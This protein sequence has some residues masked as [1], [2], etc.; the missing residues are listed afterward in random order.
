MRLEI[1]M[2]MATCLVN[3][4][5]VRC[6]LAPCFIRNS[7]SVRSA[8]SLTAALWLF[9]L[10]YNLVL[11]LDGAIICDIFICSLRFAIFGIKGHSS[12]CSSSCCLLSDR[13]IIHRFMVSRSIKIVSDVRFSVISR[14][15]TTC[16]IYLYIF[17]IS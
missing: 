3:D 17:S 14:L 7:A 5:F 16:F 11:V 12:A 6:R 2:N 15:L 1:I 4:L 10:I 9:S 8:L 13:D